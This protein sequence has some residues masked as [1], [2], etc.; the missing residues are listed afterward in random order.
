[1]KL[2][3]AIRSKVLGAKGSLS[4]QTIVGAGWLIGSRFLTK[5]IDFVGLIV[6]ARLLVP[7]DFGVVAM[8][9]TLVQLAEAALE[10]PLFQVLV[11]SKDLTD[12]LLSTAFSLGVARGATLS[13]ALVALSFLSAQVYHEA[14]LVGLISFLSLAPAL[15]GAVSPRMVVFSRSMDFRRD[16]AL[17]VVSKVS[18][19]VVSAT[20]AFATRSYWAIALGTVLTPAIGVLGSYFVAPYRPRLTL[21]HWRTFADLLG[22]STAAQL[23]TA[24]NWQSDRPILRLFV[25]DA[26]LGRYSLANDLSLIPEQALVKP[27]YQPLLSGF[28]SISSDHARLRGAYLRAEHVL[29]AVGTPMLV[30][31]AFLATPATRLA[32]GGKWLSAAPI[33]QWLA[34]TLIVPLF[35]AALGPLA[36]TLGK[37]R[38]FLS[39]S[40][41]ELTVRLPLT[42]GLSWK[43]GVEGMII[44]RLLTGIVNTGT[45]MFFVRQLIGASFLQQCLVGWRPVLS[46]A[47]MALVLTIS[48]PA[49]RSLVSVELFLGLCLV[50]ALGLSAYVV[51]YVTL[52]LASGRPDGF[53]ARFF[54]RLSR[55]G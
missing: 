37:T 7:A 5:L 10:L 31:L 26:L 27:I 35:A 33:V 36:V 21:V 41:V 12:D 32:L 16:V 55:W 4:G 47:V 19:L 39:Q 2:F 42:L 30:G 9:M 22:W 6:L 8:A 45:S 29:V 24:V 49:L 15:R 28:S 44:A 48:R 34:L 50:T 1:M 14:R 51:A 13:L 43:L 38:I 25:S 53:E 11:R 52:W 20:V 40:L 23:T 18:A 54:R 17:D 3:R 46:G